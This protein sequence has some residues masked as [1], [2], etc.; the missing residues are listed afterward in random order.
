MSEIG[1]HG[2]ISRAVES[3]RSEILD[4]TRDLIRTPSEN[5]PGDEAGIAKIIVEKLNRLGIVDI[6]VLEKKAGRS[7]IIARLQGFRKEPVLMLNAHIDTK[8]IGERDGWSTDPFSG[9]IRNGEMYGRGSVDMKST[10][11]AMILAASI[12]KESGLSLGGT[13]LLAMTADEEAGGSLGVGWLV[14]EK[15]IRADA[16]IVGEPS[17]VNESFEYLDVSTRGVYAFD[18]TAKGTQMHS[19]LSDIKRGV[20]AS[21]KLAKILTR[22]PT[23]LKLEHEPDPFYPQGLTINPGVFVKG[24]V[25]YGVL[26][27]L[28]TAGNDIR[29][30]PKM[31]KDK[32]GEDIDHWLNKLKAEDPEL[33]VSA[34][35][36]LWVDGAE[37]RPE[38]PIVKSCARAYKEVF[39]REPK[40]GGFPGA[41]DARFM[42]NKGHF[43][44]VPAF[45]PGLL[46]LAHGPDERVPVEDII[47]ATKIYAIAALGYLGIE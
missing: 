25:W 31:S 33:D 4:F 44:A 41:V 6:E 3:R 20:N 14:E 8:P 34:E 1:W 5:P 18:L 28:C 15:G 35:L 12:I 30:L 19:S 40:I 29:T 21:L 22:M 10:A 36:K 47:R 32:V 38:E 17:G 2:R 37:I 26:P 16:A 42:I 13:I 23:E 46:H 9:I 11:A 24:G 43:P 7:N 27:G 39:G 45:G